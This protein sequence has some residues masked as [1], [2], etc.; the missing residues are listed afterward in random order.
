MKRFIFARS[1]TFQAFCE[2]LNCSN[3]TTNKHSFV[4]VGSERWFS[5][6]Y[7]SLNLQ[8]ENATTYIHFVFINKRLCEIL[9]QCPFFNMQKNGPKNVVFSP[10]GTGDLKLYQSQGLGTFWGLFIFVIKPVFYLSWQP[11]LLIIYHTSR[12]HAP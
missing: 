11:I 8:N 10:L 6:K 2:D 1:S 12:A 4:I 5:F 3:Q 9:M 7:V